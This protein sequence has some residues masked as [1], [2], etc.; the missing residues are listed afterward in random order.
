METAIN[1]SGRFGKWLENLVDWNS[2]ALVT[3]NTA[4]YG[5]PRI[6]K[7][8]MYRFSFRT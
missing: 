6:K 4:S 5:S 8:K 3:G 7:K 2:H 1:S